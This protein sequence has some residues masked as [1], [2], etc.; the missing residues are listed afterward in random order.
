MGEVIHVFL[1]PH[2]HIK[3]SSLVIQKSLYLISLRKNSKI[4]WEFRNS[5]FNDAKEKLA[6]TEGKKGRERELSSVAH[7][8]FQSIQLGNIIIVIFVNWSN[9]T[10][11][12]KT[13]HNSHGYICSN[14]QW[15]KMIDFSFMLKI[16]RILSK[17][18]V[19]WRYFE[20]FLP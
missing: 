14:S 16:I 20:N 1:L 19:P 12:H 7:N 9:V 4:S 2:C 18:Q 5:M 17:D 11:D 13:S 15:V 10:L 8:V 6:K 3:Q